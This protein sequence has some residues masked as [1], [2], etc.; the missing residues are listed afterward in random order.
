MDPPYN[1]VYRRF[2]W[3]N[4]VPPEYYHVTSDPVRRRNG[5]ASIERMTPETWHRT[6]QEEE[7]DPNRHCLPVP[8]LARP[9]DRGICHCNVCTWHREN[10]AKKAA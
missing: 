8:F 4:G 5:G 6:T 2:H 9:A 10:D 7:K 3:V 1:I